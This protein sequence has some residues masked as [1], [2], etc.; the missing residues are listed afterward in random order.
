MGRALSSLHLLPPEHRDTIDT[1][2]LS[3]ATEA[4]AGRTDAALTS[5]MPGVMECLPVLEKLER[6]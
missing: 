1:I 6:G 2:D 3:L 5:R 4:D